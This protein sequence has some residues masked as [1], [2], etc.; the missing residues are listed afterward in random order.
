MRL[1]YSLSHSYLSLALIHTV[2]IDSEGDESVLEEQYVKEL[3]EKH[4]E[5]SKK[6]PKFLS[7]ALKGLPE[8][9][10]KKIILSCASLL[11]FTSLISLL[12]SPALI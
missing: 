11:S 10:G 6:V 5:G 3:A 7:S 2:K 9:Y 1:K 12:P 8:R 4:S